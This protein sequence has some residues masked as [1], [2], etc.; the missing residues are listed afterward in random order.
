MNFLSNVVSNCSQNLQHFDQF[1]ADA[2]AGTLPHFSWINP[3]SGV[4]GMTGEGSNDGHP[5]HD[6]ALTDKFLGEIYD[7]VRSSPQ[8]PL[9]VSLM[10]V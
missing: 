5:S 3:R 1:L 9:S 4:D 2:K 8:V 10:I 7:A 6:L